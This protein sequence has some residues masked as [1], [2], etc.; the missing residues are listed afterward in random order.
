M[1]NLKWC[2][3]V[4]E[5]DTPPLSSNECLQ[6]VNVASFKVSGM[7]C[8]VLFFLLRLLLSLVHGRWNRWVTQEVKYVR[9]E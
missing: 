3:L 9:N 4:R 5:V 6:G 2:M 8:Y 1:V 7:F